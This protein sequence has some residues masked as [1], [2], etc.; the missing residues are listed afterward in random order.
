MSWQKRRNEE[1]NVNKNRK[2]SVQRRVLKREKEK[3][4]QKNLNT[5]NEKV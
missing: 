2:K 3:S 5:N 1:G 4:G